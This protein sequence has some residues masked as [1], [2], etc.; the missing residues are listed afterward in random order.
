MC[1]DVPRGYDTLSQIV[2]PGEDYFEVLKRF[3]YQLRPKSYLEIGVDIGA[4]IVLAKSP[5]VAI[6][7]DPAPRI[8]STPQTIC[9]IFPMTSDEYFATRDV[10]SDIETET[11]DL[12]FIDGMHLF[13]QALRDFINVERFSSPSTVVLIHDCF[14]IDAPTASRQR[15][16][17][18][19]TGDVWK[20]VPCLKEFRPD[21]NI[22]TIATP[23]SGLGVVSGLN[24]RSTVLINQFEQ[25]VSR[26][27]GLDLDA[28]E[29]QRRELAAMLENDWQQVVRR[30]PEQ[31]RASSR[32]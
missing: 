2:F 15:K 6:G 14:A 25:I 3:H 4:S 9:K 22:F 29:A 23:P 7:I 16:T 12:A 30:L 13:E 8:A 24:T 26:Y 20:I 27:I 1:P 31:F 21:L 18:F 19:W 32:A 17:A 10:R 28:D 5:T 11:V